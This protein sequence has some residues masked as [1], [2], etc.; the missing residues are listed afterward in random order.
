MAQN[1]Y[2]PHSL[3]NHNVGG[4]IMAASSTSS[5]SR[6]LHSSIV[7]IVRWTNWKIINNL[8]EKIWF[9]LGDLF[10]LFFLTTPPHFLHKN[11]VWIHT[12]LMRNVRDHKIFL[13]QN[14]RGLQVPCVWPVD[15]HERFFEHIFLPKNQFKP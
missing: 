13:L 7:D 10:I 6:S 3:K 12:Y 15:P 2:K 8:S 1:L 9:N 14:C 11:S 4:C 5:C